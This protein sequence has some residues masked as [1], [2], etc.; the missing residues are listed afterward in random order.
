MGQ[1]GRALALER[2]SSERMVESYLSL[3]ERARGQ[4]RV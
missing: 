4:L 1:R 2:Y 3:Y